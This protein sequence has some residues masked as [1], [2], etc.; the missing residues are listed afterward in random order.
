MAKQAKKIAEI[1]PLEDIEQ[2][3]YL[4]RGRKVILDRDLA[5]LYHVET[6]VLNQAVTRNLRRFPDDFMFELTRQEIMRISQTVTSSVDLKFSKRVRGFTEQGVAMLSSVLRSERAIDVNIAIMRTFVK[7][8]RMLETHGKL[9][10]K[11]AEL[12]NKYDEQFR[13]VFE[14]LN[15]LMD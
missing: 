7:L 2:A 15:E 12:E 5:A 14:V 11:L 9:A 6:R 3:I 8:R 1:A 10:G 13:V 4:I